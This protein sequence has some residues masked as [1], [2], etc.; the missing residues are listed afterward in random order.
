[1][2][3]RVENVPNECGGLFLKILEHRKSDNYRFL[4]L[5]GYNKPVNLTLGKSS[6][7]NHVSIINKSGY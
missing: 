3:H 2:L 5:N 4:V 7:E 1:M 6:T